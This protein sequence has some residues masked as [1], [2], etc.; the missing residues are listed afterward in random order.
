MSDTITTIYLARHC[1]VENPKG[2]LY[3]FLPGFGL[4]QKGRE[5]ARAMGRFFSDKPVAQLI[6]SPLQRAQE[7]AEA[8]V[9]ANPNLQIET[10]DELAE[11]GFAKYY[12][13]LRPLDVAWRRPKWIRHKLFPGMLAQDEGI[14]GM[15]TRVRGPIMRILRDHPGK[16]GICISHGDPIQAFWNIAEGSHRFVTLHCKK[17]GIL[18]LTYR[19]TELSNI[20]YHSPESIGA[21]ATPS[22]AQDIVSA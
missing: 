14:R 3:G 18:E 15:A 10:S 1:D 9:A 2:V 5:Q 19:G 21:P 4:S 12:Q 8:I 7:T 13:G 11:A 6:V 16:G 17:G 22:V 20:T